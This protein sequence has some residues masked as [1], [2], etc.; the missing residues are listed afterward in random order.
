MA[1]P[2]LWL[3]TDKPYDGQFRRARTWDPA[4]GQWSTPVYEKGHPKAGRPVM[5]RIPGTGYEGSPKNAT[6]MRRRRFVE[7]LRH[8]GHIVAVPITNAAAHLPDSDVS[9]ETD[10]RLKGKYLGWIEKGQCPAAMLAGNLLPAEQFAADTA[11]WT[12]CNPRTLG[13]KNPPCPHFIAEQNARKGRRGDETDALEAKY[14]SE[15]EKHT[16]AIRDLATNLTDVVKGAIAPAS[17][18]VAKG[19]K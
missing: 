8:D 14:A 15:A 6:P 10:R 13:E 18:P 4:S 2:V 11:G 5:E 1:A 7:M 17:P 19:G 9:C 12:P 3:K 16:A